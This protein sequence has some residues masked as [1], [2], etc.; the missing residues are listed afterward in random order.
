MGLAGM[1]PC[2]VVPPRIDLD[3]LLAQILY[4]AGNIAALE[5]HQIDALAVLGEELADRLARVGGLE[6]LDVPD[7]RGQDR[8]E[9]AEPLGL[10][11]RVHLVAEELLV[12]LDGRFQIPHDDGQLYHVPQHG[13]AKC[14]PVGRRDTSIDGSVPS[15]VPDF[16]A[17]LT[18][19]LL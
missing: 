6:Q 19:K 12:A 15:S 5:A 4:R 2:D 14:P 7:A 13:H 9:E 18:T 16:G 11:A 3:A 17:Q 10:P 8:V 1:Q